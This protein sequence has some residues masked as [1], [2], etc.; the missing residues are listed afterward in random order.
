MK[1]HS[2]QGQSLVIVVL[3]MFLMLMLAALTIDVSAWYQTHHRAQVV[4]DAAALAA[5]NCLANASTTD[6]TN[7]N[8]CTT[9]TDTTHAL[10]V[11]TNIAKSN[12]VTLGASNV[13]VGTSAVTV[14]TPIQAPEF[15]A[16][17]VG[18]SS[19]TVSAHA[20]ASFL[21]GSG[22]VWTCPSTGAT[23]CVS[24]FAGNTTCPSSPSSTVGLDLVTN[25]SGGGTST[26]YDMYTNG[27]YWNGGASGA[28]SYE[29]GTPGSGGSASC[30]SDHMKKSSTTTFTYTSGAI[31]YTAVWTQPTCT[32]SNTATYWT[33]S[34]SAPA[35]N[36][37]GA[38]GVYCVT[39]SPAGSGSP[40]CQDGASGMTAGYID[41]DESSSL[42]TAGGGY[43]FVAP[44]V[45][46][47][48]TTSARIQSIAGQP[49]V[50]GT[51]NIVTSATKTALPTC[52][53]ASNNGTAGSSTFIDGNGADIDST[54]YDQCGTVE[55]TQNNN[56]V[57][58]VEAWNIIVDKNNTV[59]GNGPSSTGGGSVTTP[60]GTDSLSG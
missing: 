2:E 22:N 23:N 46:L 42:L 52:T 32:G 41:V 18:L 6:S 10:G 27:E 9:T 3:C 48:G 28:A 56:F 43:E 36:Q 55:Y 33:T 8:M 37:I 45:T 54:M 49:L 20:V 47:S 14:T 31:P 58:Y 39:A 26:M 13:A 29:V 51:S 59:T 11:A 40:A 53:A 30:G 34:G 4:A 16:G 1:L 50:Y 25:D 21:P 38:P 7:T 15:F 17:I 12:G 5:A 60:G 44:C 35:A 19:P 24:L 57:G